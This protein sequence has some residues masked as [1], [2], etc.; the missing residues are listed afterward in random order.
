MLCSQSLGFLEFFGRFVDFVGDG[1]GKGRAGI[2]LHLLH[3]LD[4]KV[5]WMDWDV[6]ASH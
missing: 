1:G 2:G 4:A 5:S 3:L 6:I